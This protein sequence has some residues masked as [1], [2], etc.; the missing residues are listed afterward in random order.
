MQ[1]VKPDWIYSPVKQFVRFLIKVT[2]KRFFVNVG[3][4]DRK[5]TVKIY[6]KIGKSQPLLPDAPQHIQ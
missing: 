4:L 3:R 5:R 1:P 6:R 2:A